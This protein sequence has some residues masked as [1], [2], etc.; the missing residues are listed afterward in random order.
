VILMRWVGATSKN[1]MVR[2]VSVKIITR[3]NL[4]GD[5][6]RFLLFQEVNPR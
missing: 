6:L 1:E 4:V 2:C 3:D 5:V